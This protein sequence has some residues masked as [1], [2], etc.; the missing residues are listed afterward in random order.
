MIALAGLVGGI[1]RGTLSGA[2]Q[3]VIFLL[4]V[5]QRR[6]FCH[7]H[8]VGEYHNTVESAAEHV[9]LVVIC[10]RTNGKLPKR[11]VHD[12]ASLQARLCGKHAVDDELHQASVKG[13]G[14]VVPLPRGK[15]ELVPGV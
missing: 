12:P 3:V 6:D 7:P 14:H 11:R 13:S 9:R 5:V 15:F 1:T 8:S 10:P 2:A 4:K